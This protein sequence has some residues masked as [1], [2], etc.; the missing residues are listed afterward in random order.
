MYMRVS[1]YVH[2]SVNVH[3]YIMNT[4]VCVCVSFPVCYRCTDLSVFQVRLTE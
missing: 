3:Y 2:T 4:V 1:V